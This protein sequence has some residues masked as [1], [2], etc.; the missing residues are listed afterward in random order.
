MEVD[1]KKDKEEFLIKCSY[2]E[3][4]NDNIIDLLDTNAL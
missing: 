1:L 2:F 3:I 4:Y